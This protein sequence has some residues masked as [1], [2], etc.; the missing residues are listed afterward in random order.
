MTQQQYILHNG[1]TYP[2]KA[3]VRSNGV[4]CLCIQDELAVMLV[5]LAVAV[6]APIRSR[7]V[8]ATIDGRHV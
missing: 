3:K 8:L 5:P 2:V 7:P 6:V 1:R 4:D